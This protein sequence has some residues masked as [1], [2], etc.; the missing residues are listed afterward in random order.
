MRCFAAFRQRQ[1][2]L[3]PLLKTARGDLDSEEEILALSFQH[4]KQTL[5]TFTL[6]IGVEGRQK[7]PGRA[8]YL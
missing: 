8:A 6:R 2:T 3:Q 7:L 5:S 4:K 1:P